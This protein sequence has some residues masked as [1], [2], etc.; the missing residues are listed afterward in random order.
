M[1][2]TQAPTPL[3][4]RRR[5]L[6]SLVIV[7]GIVLLLWGLAWLALPPIVKG[8]AEQ[9]LS[10]LLGREVKIGR[11]AFAPWS[12]TLTVE[13]LTIA[14]AAGSAR[15]GPQ[16][17]VGR[18]VANVDLRSLW[19]LAPVIEALEIEQ[20]QLRVARTADGRYDFDDVL[21]R[22]A[23]KQAPPTPDDQ[24]VRFALYNLRLSDG[25]VE[26][27]D[28]PVQRTHQLQSLDITLPFLSNL[29]DLVAV[30]VEPRI[31]F[32][33][34]GAR[35]DTGAQSKPF[36]QDRASQ[37]TVQLSGLDLAPWLP[38]LPSGL[39]MRPSRG[40]IAGSWQIQFALAADGTPR[41]ALSGKT[42]LTNA[43]LV[44]P[45]GIASSASAPIAT[46]Q[47]LDVVL[48]EARP[49]ERVVALGTV[50]LA[51]AQLDLRRSADGRLNL[52]PA[53][54]PAAGAASASAPSSG[55]A[56]RF[57]ADKV[58]LI[59]ARVDW[60]DATTRPGAALRIDAFDAA[61]GPLQ[62]PAAQPAPWRVV[63]RLSA[64]AAAASA[65][66]FSAEGQASD[67]EASARMQFDA[68]DLAWLRPYF[69]PHLTPRIDG[70]LKAS[71]TLGWASD[72]QAP[73][74]ALSDLFTSISALRI[75]EA[76][77][78]A[79]ARPALTLAMLGVNEGTVDL[80]AQRIKLGSLTLERPALG[81]VRQRD[82]LLNLQRWVVASAAPPAASPKAAP[83]WQVELGDFQ[84]NGG[85][86]RWRDELPAAAGSD[87]TPDAE[88]APTVRAVASAINARVSGFAWPRGAPARTQL[89][90]TLAAG[91]SAAAKGA[92]G[93]LAWSGQLA[94]TPLSARGTLKAERVPLAAFAPYLD[95]ELPIEVLRGEAFWRGNVAVTQRDAGLEADL[96]GDGQLNDLRVHERQA[97]ARGDELLTWQSLALGG[98]RVTMRP[99]TKPQIEI[100]D[101]ALTDFY[102]RLVITEQ[103]RFN[104]RDV[105][106][107]PAAAAT[108][109]A[110]TTT[111]SVTPSA[112]AAAASA[113][114]AGLPIDIRVGGTRLVNGRIDFTDRFVKPNYSAALSEL[115]GKLGAFSST[116]RDM[117][118]LELRGRAAGTALLEIAGSLNPTAQPLALDIRAKAT[119]LELAPFS[120]YAGRY[121]GYAIE[122]GKLSMDVAYKIDADGKLD[123][124]NQVV[125][126]QLTFGDKV[127]SADATKLPV[128]LVVA[129]LKDRNGVID[130]NLPV[131]GSIND[132][133]FSVF[134]IVLK[135]IGN[136]LVKALT[137][138]F[139]LLSGGGSDDLSFVAFDPGTPQVTEA[140]R[141]TIDKVSKALQDRPA[142]KMTVTG[143][144]D[145]AS[146]REA[147]QRAALEA[148]LRAEQR[149]ELLR[150]GAPANAPLPAL[151]PAQ[152]DALV[153]RVYADTK[154]PDKPRN[155]IGLAKDIPVAEMEALLRKATVVSTDSARD[156]ALQRGLAVR[157]ALIAKDLPSE[158]LFLAAPKL[159]AS[160]EDEAAWSP[161]VQLALSTN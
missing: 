143:A 129:L 3:T 55:A 160:G 10:A 145:P 73:K 151:A 52:M 82:G 18:V 43:A 20:P 35:F 138:P 94:P 93:T 110:T 25:A 8:Q 15:A 146:E 134:G 137:S 90:L 84:L 125:L 136:L 67:R 9:R 23:S 72:A 139:A 126:N 22:L 4:P 76:G 133:Q 7:G 128:L 127:E 112:P 45:A 12:L 152:R 79:R 46:W 83:G 60:S 54:T 66:T 88:G 62:W 17:S 63:G 41:V 141:A 99:G 40:V 11:V 123:A 47:R 14:S 86:V 122:R 28:R 100:G 102:S 130:I 132:P 135:I 51:G 106:A 101:A 155:V 159:R 61:V 81:L 115:N 32:K 26:F 48:K 89:Q 6:R 87:L 2:D 37:L 33:L 144:A 105:A 111:A 16:F 71:A 150:A 142:L 147:I 21:E 140:G 148:A 97:S 104:L 58:E 95:R 59:G 39:P 161:R 34:D 42:S 65:A 24:P 29:P 92:G 5:L 119:D 50:T 30:N 118:T 56:W 158:R 53:V 31:A 19:R 78:N 70:T 13:Q 57:S 120:P 1:S 114:A 124:K 75:S 91:D 77:A 113:A 68:L 131:S 96:Q 69:A 156:L 103:G 153:K 157:D 80:L 27:D 149:R 107:P 121:A 117:A 44:G 98:L 74:L 116:S 108:S 154:L 49:L 85:E 36:A 38:Y 64:P 109:A